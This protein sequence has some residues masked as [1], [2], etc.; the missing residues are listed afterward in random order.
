M[1]GLS[2]TAFGPDR[3]LTRGEAA[4]VLCRLAGLSPRGSG[5]AFSDLRGH[6]AAGMSRPPMRPGWP[7]GW[8]AAG[9]LPTSRSPGR[10]SPSCWTG[11]GP[12]SG[13]PR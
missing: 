11:S 12:A 6:W 10:R 1:T 3:T 7:P 13:G 9:T 5:S 8:A 4:V 2:H